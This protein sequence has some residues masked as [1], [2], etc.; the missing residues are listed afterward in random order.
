MS[1]ISASDVELSS[2][3]VVTADEVERRAEH[4]HTV[5]VVD[6]NRRVVGW[7]E[8]GSVEL[9]SCRRTFDPGRDNLRSVID[10]LLLSPANAAVATAPTGEVLGLA[11]YS[12]VAAVIARHRRSSHA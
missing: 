12:G 2:R 4:G 11:D 3:D 6:E 7:K 9:L 8:N 5:L 1:L 10:A